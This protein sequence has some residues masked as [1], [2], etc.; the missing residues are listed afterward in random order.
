MEERPIEYYESKVR[1]M[2]DKWYDARVKK[3]GGAR[4]CDR[5]LENAVTAL[6]TRLAK[7]PKPP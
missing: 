5:A 6:R 7:L 1:A 3:V 4:D 2:V